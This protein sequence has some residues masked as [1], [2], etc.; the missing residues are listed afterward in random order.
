MGHPRG[1][2]QVVTCAV[3]SLGRRSELCLWFLALWPLPS[4]PT[5][6]L[7]APVSLSSFGC[8]HAARI[9]TDLGTWYRHLRWAEAV[10]L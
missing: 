6:R 3:W 4:M 5:P 10:S 7:S 8:G 2:V 9:R 1:G